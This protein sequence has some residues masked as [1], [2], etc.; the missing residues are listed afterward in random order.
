[1]DLIEVPV[2]PAY[3]LAAQALITMQAAER[4]AVVVRRPSKADVLVFAKGLTSGVRKHFEISVGE[5]ADGGDED[6]KVQSLE[7]VTGQGNVQHLMD[8][9]GIK[10]GLHPTRNATSATIVAQHEGFGVMLQSVTLCRCGGNPS[11]PYTDVESTG[12]CDLDGTAITCG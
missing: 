1:M 6:G 2:V 9:R 8:G 7:V 11:H 3:T 12:V 5:I 10:F 4:A